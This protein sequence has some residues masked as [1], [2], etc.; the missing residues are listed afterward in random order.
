MKTFA[1]IGSCVRRAF[2]AVFGA[3]SPQAQTKPPGYV[4]IEFKVKD[5]E[6]SRPTDSALLPPSPNTA[7]SSWCAAQSPRP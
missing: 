4:V 6:A 5:A 3:S 2:A 1:K 7:V